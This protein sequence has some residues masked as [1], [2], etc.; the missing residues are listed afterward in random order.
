ELLAGRGVAQALR[1]EPTHL[2][3]EVVTVRLRAVGSEADTEA[4]IGGLD[5][6]EHL[7]R[8]PVLPTAATQIEIRERLGD[9]PQRGVVRGPGAGRA[10]AAVDRGAAAV[11]QR[12][13]GKVRDVGVAPRSEMRA[14]NGATP[15]D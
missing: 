6:V 9:R 8:A 7:P 15:A 5:L 11:D 2:L 4:R 14:E 12:A 13:F 1:A 3:V 10:G